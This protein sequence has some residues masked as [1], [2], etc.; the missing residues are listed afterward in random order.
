MAAAFVD[1]QDVGRLK[2]RDPGL[3]WRSGQYW[4]MAAKKPGKTG[5]N[6]PLPL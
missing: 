3:P 4:A 5:K 6:T 1:P 2:A